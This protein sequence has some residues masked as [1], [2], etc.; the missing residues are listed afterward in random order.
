MDAFNAM[1]LVRILSRSLPFP[2]FLFFLLFFLYISAICLSVYQSVCMPLSVIFVFIHLYSSFTSFSL[3][4]FF[5]C[6]SIFLFVFNFAFLHSFALTLSYKGF[7]QRIHSQ[8]AIV[9]SIGKPQAHSWTSTS[10]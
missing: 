9:N 1:S 6:L 7:Y 2:L 3:S 10:T 4:F 5:L 8:E